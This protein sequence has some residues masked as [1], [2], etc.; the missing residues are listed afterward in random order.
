MT[1]NLTD[2]DWIYKMK[3]AIEDGQ[4]VLV[5]SIQEDI[6]PILDNLLSRNFILRNNKL[7]VILDGDEPTD[8]D[9][10]FKLYL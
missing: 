1:L 4:I 2:D 7:K 5:E 9:P 6:D 10:A 3:M 8:I